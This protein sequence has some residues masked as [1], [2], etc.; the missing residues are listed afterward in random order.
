MFTYKSLPS[1]CLDIL[2]GFHRNFIEM[3]S[4]DFSQTSIIKKHY[5]FDGFDEQFFVEDYKV[6][7][8]KTFK[9]EF[10]FFNAF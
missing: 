9:C 3:R 2:I 4:L 10:N 5:L 1:F 7:G 8:L 6:K